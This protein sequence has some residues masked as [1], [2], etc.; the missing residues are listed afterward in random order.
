MSRP[1]GDID[2]SRNLEF[3]I[4]VP[5]KVATPVSQSAFP[6]TELQWNQLKDQIKKIR[7][8][9]SRWFTTSLA[10]LTFSVSFFISIILPTSTDVWVDVVL[11]VGTGAGLLGALLCFIFYKASSKQ[12]IDDI[13]TVL[14]HMDDIRRTYRQ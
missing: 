13:Q 2:S 12:R 9:E 8:G 3:E 6:V 14:N 11:W 5:L 10:F 7:C 1:S 4:S